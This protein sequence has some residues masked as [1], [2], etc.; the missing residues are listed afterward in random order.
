MNNYIFYKITYTLHKLGFYYYSVKYYIK[1]NYQKNNKFVLINLFKFIITFFKAFFKEIKI[2][3]NNSGY[4]EYIEIP[5]T[6]KCSL[7]C[8]ACSNLI[9]YYE[10]PCDINIDTLIESI[11]VFT[12]C[13]NNIVYVRLLRWRTISLKK[14]RNCYK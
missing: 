2:F 12:K 9:P 3:S 14:F 10:K 7:K 8:K 11:D 4:Y 6:T 13:I 5:I 1:D